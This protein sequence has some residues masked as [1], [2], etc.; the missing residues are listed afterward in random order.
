M[1]D[2]VA[3]SGTAEGRMI[4]FVDHLHEHFVTPVVVAGGRYLAPVAPGAGTEMLAD[5][6]AAHRYDDHAGG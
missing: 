2:L 1:F 4:E 5:S 3:V 6:I